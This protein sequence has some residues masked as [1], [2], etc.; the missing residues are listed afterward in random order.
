MTRL[1]PAVV[2]AVGYGLAVLLLSNVLESLP[3]GSVYAIWAGVG[4]A[5]AAAFGVW[6]Y[7]EQLP[8]PAW[9]GIALVAIGVAM[10][11]YYTPHQS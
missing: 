3:V 1:G 8:L 5:G 4:T 7:Q 6:Y 9:I 2:V 11:G 10:L